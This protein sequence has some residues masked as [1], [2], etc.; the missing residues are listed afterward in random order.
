MQQTGLA[1][2]SPRI[3]VGMPQGQNFADA[4]I[5]K[6]HSGLTHVVKSEWPLMVKVS[7]WTKVTASSLL[8]KI[9]SYAD[10]PACYCDCCELEFAAASDAFRSR[11]VCS[12]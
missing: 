7:A 10:R 12:V 11:T 4:G 6:S 5:T 1:H 9:C 8:A 3:D 2:L